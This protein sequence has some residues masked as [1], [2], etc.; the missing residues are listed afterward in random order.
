M[1]SLP[2]TVIAVLGCSLLSA[3]TPAPPQTAR[4]ALI[5]MFFGSAANHLER[6]LPDVTRKTLQRLD[7]GDGQS[8]LS[9]FAMIAAGAKTSGV[10]LQTFDVGPTLLSADQPERGAA[11]HVEITVERDDLM[12]DEDQIELALHITKNGK[13]ESL[14]FI[15]HF[16]FAMKSEADVWR[17]NEISVTIRVPLADPDFLKTIEERQRAQNEQMVI[18]S[19][20]TVNESEK[21]YAKSQGAYACTLSA[22]TKKGANTQV[23]WDTQ[24]ASGKKGG[25]IYAISSCD[26]SHYKIVA[27][28]A[29]PD[30]GQRAFCSDE[31]G[32]VRAAADGKA[33]S[34]LSGGEALEDPA[35]NNSDHMVG[36][37][38]T[39]APAATQSVA[40]APPSTSATQ[41]MAPQ[42]VRVSSS[43]AQGLVISKV[44]PV[45][46]DIARTARVQG[47]VVIKALISKTGD[48][49]QEEVV[50][51]P[52]L[53]T[54]AA[55]DA[56]RQWKYRSYILQGQPVEVETQ[57]TVSFQ[58]VTR[59]QSDSAH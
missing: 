16:T 21:G 9:Q 19:L 51:G 39:A 54:Q 2:A 34:C 37:H 42:R 20:R 30:S 36:A 55:L 3:Q 48:V 10:N 44:Q 45:Y 40:T 52:P 50:S 46:P 57:I 27:E 33:A 56:V 29:V 26:A 7:S 14:P 18:W 47:S 38:I 13:E 12:G 8:L 43:V 59:S 1:R 11:E 15:P 35:A 4:Q 22:L 32:T 24:L 49:I 58:L 53:L 31:G 23:L 17:L 6:H 28:P 41:S 25:Y 5:E